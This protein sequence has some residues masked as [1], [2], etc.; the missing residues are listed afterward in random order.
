MEASALVMRR[1]IKRKKMGVRTSGVERGV[2]PACGDRQRRLDGSKRAATR[3]LL[4]FSHLLP[5]KHKRKGHHDA[6]CACCAPAMFPSTPVQTSGPA[7]A[8]QTC[9]PP[10][11]RAV[12]AA[13][14]RLSP[15]GA[16]TGTGEQATGCA[17]KTG[18]ARM[19]AS[20]TLGSSPPASLPVTVKS[21]RPASPKETKRERTS[22]S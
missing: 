10:I 11:Q 20:Y 13:C 16:R 19:E 17:S 8:R 15:P 1:E 6:R 3:L 4:L 18:G 12:G 9:R 5:S 14:I 2:P 7:P 21:A 22:H